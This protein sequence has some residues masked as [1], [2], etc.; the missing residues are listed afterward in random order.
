MY[1]HRWSEGKIG[2]IVDSI[3]SGNHG[4]KNDAQRP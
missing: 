2:L 4:W 1:T 3:Q